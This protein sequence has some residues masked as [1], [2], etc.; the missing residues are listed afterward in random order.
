[1]DQF[2]A[3]SKIVLSQ[4]ERFQDNGSNKYVYCLFGINITCSVVELYTH[5]I[6]D[7]EDVLIRPMTFE[8]IC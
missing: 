7:S 4:Q 5:F 3:L 1:M 8:K 2:F 6:V